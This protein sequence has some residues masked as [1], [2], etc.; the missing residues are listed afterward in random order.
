MTTSNEMR[1]SRGKR[2]LDYYYVTVNRSAVPEAL[3]TI[4]IDAITD[5]LHYISLDDDINPARITDRALNHYMDEL[6][7]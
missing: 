2:L 6:Y 3:E 7:D 1:Q 4:A 5:I